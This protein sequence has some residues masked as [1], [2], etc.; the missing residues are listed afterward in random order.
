MPDTAVVAGVGPGFC[1]SFAR[2]LGRAGHP[3]ALFGRSDDYL[4][5]FAAEL[6]ADGHEALAVP[7]DVTDPGAVDEAFAEVREELGPVE[8]LAHTASTVTTPS[9][10]VLD[11]DRFERMWRLYA[12]GGL[13]C[14]REALEDLEA[15]GGTIL[16]FGAAPESGDVAFKSGKDATR[17]LARS[18]ADEYGPA[19][20]HVAHVVIDGALLN[21][22]V[23]ETEGDVDER[24]YIDPDAAAE[25]C[26]HLV[27]QP[28]RARTF[29]LDLHAT[30]RTSP[31]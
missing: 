12:Y 4:A 8:V 24:A 28:D 9:G 10:S 27:D 15:S 16:F 14:A 29:E 18:L 5:E 20:V 19:G 7:T 3:V 22:D 23:Y 30:D 25:T 2:K 11:P 17:G 31:R 1:E 6:R 21:P 26:Y 13:L